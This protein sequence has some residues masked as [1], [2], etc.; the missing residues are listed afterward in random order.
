MAIQVRGATTQSDYRLHVEATL[1]QTHTLGFQ[2]CVR[3]RN[4]VKTLIPD[5]DFEDPTTLAERAQRFEFVKDL[6]TAP[7]L[8]TS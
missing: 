3:E 1:Q 2:V 4:E 8:G 6:L 7:T 5:L